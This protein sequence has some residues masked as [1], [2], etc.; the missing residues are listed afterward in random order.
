MSLCISIHPIK[1]Y[2]KSFRVTSI[3]RFSFWQKLTCCVLISRK[4]QSSHPHDDH[5]LKESLWVY[6]SI[7]ASPTQFSQRNTTR[8]RRQW[9]KF[10]VLPSA[11]EFP[12]IEG[13]KPQTYNRT[14]LVHIRIPICTNVIS[15][16]YV[17]ITNP[18]DPNPLAT[19]IWEPL[20]HKDFLALRNALRVLG[21]LATSWPGVWT[22]ELV[23]V[24]ETLNWN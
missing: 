22:R 1:S 24:W 4:T 19:T 21:S 10:T 23:E 9:F 13:T 15:I 16:W 2:L 11:R 18:E 14:S 3:V 5:F 6:A 17:N 12:F 20:L 8:K 7:T